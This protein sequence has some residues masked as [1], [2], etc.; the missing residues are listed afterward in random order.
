[1]SDSS[2]ITAILISDVEIMPGLDVGVRQ[3]LERGGTHAGMGTHADTHQGKLG[4]S[5]FRLH[6]H[7]GAQRCRHGFERRLGAA[8]SLAGMVKDWR[9]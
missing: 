7:I 9:T 3:G 5:G 4:E 2:T 6:F 1:M 8:S